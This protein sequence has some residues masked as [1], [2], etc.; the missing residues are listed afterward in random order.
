[1]GSRREELLRKARRKILLQKAKQKLSG[2]VGDLGS[3]V[4][5]QHP[6]IST[7]DRWLVKNLSQ[8]PE[9]SLNYLK[10][11]YPD[12]EIEMS[13]DGQL[14]AKSKGGKWMAIDPDNHGLDYSKGGLKEFGKDVGDIG[15]DLYAGATEGAAALGGAALGAGVSL[16]AGMTGAIPGAMLAGG[17]ATAAN[18]GIRQKLGQWLGLPQDVSGE[19]VLA[20]GAIGAVAPAISGAGKVPGV[21]QKAMEYGGKATRAINPLPFIGE[22]VSGVPRQILRDYADDGVREAVKRL[23]KEGIT[24]FSGKVFDK[25]KNYI[26][27]NKEKAGQEL[28]EA[29]EGAGRKANVAPAKGSFTSRVDE[30]QKN[31]P[32]TEAD[33][34]AINAVL[35]D[36]NKYFGLAEDAQTRLNPNRMVLE[37]SPSFVP[38]ELT[39]KKAWDIQKQLKQVADFEKSDLTPADLARKGAARDSYFKINEALDEASEGLSSKA[40]DRY[41]A[42]IKE[43]A[44]LL[45]RFEGRTRADSIQKTYNEMS[46]LDR[47]GRKVMQEKLSKLSDDEILNLAD[48]AKI[49]STYRWLGN[50]NVAP[51]SSAGTTSTSRTIPLAIAGGSLGSLAGYNTGQGY[52]GATVG[53]AGGA[54]LGTMLGSP[55]AMKAYIRAMRAAGRSR[56]LITPR[57]TPVNQA[58]GSGIITEGLNE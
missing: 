45:P 18:E 11:K 15:Y 51:V 14:R 56:E 21:A 46:R 2:Y 12:L 49:L 52:A 58:I 57:A 48:E 1:M 43:E 44:E 4:Q 10:Q 17:A 55:A 47:Q 37:K 26:E 31:A 24:D 16:P 6:D 13:G 42:A 39:P 36:Y 20:S 54:A 41:S 3:T 50:P 23:E 22:K 29:I 27:G 19:D 53:G 40:K 30:I 7:A 38:D 33:Q 8:S 32:V 9:A 25:L 28:V 34:K 5:E 35:G